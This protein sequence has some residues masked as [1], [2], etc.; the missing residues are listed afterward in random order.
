MCRFNFTVICSV[1]FTHTHEKDV[2]CPI[3]QEQNN[4]LW[5][6]WAVVTYKYSVFIS[7]SCW[8]SSQ[9][10]P[11]HNVLWLSKYN[12]MLIA[13]FKLHR[14]K[15]GNGSTHKLGWGCW[16]DGGLIKTWTV[17]VLC[18][19]SFLCITSM[20]E[21]TLWTSVQQNCL[22]DVMGSWVT[23]Q[24]VLCPWRTNQT[25]RSSQLRLKNRTIFLIQQKP[26]L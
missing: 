1:S 11:K 18:T 2:D 15:N 7:N 26:L 9:I 23:A 6:A 12:F 3:T 22:R 21:L 16:G 5:A 14:V 19:T 4:N 10:A 17:N 8:L 13:L 20:V 24:A 25:V